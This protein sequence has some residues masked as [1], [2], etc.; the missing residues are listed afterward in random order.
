[1][2]K[3]GL[4]NQYKQ[5]LRPMGI[6]Q[7]KNL[8]NGKIFIGSSSNLKGKL[9]SIKFQLEMGSYIN[10]ELQKD[11]IQFGEKNFLFETIDTL[12]PKQDPGYDYAEDLKTLEE[13]WLEKLQPF[14]EKGYNKRKDK[15]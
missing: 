3:K 9:N 1:M 6:F 14:I 4:K 2:D 8:A 15:V 5:T 10:K 11:F 7:I 13:M 12:E